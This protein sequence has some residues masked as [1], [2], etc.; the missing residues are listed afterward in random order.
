MTSVPSLSIPLLL[1]LLC[2]LLAD[3]LPSQERTEATTSKPAELLATLDQSY[4]DLVALQVIGESI[5]RLGASARPALDEALAEAA[6]GSNR[7]YHLRL[8]AVGARQDAALLAQLGSMVADEDSKIAALAA[9]LLGRSGAA[10]LA[11]AKELQPHTERE[12]RDG[13][14]LAISMAAA[15]AGCATMLPWLQQRLGSATNRDQRWLPQAHAMLAVGTPAATVQEWLES[16]A[17]RASAIL[18]ARTCADAELEKALLQLYPQIEDEN[19][20][21]WLLHSLG[22]IGGNDTRRALMAD[23]RRNPPREP[24]TQVD[25]RRLALLRLG[26]LEQRKWVLRQLQDNGLGVAGGISVQFVGPAMGQ[27]AEQI[28]K[29]GLIGAAQELAALT[30]DEQVQIWSRSHAARGLCWLRDQRGLLAS[31]SLMQQE[32]T[33]NLD[34]PEC[35]TRCQETLHEFVGNPDR[36]EYVV[37]QVKGFQ[38]DP[39]TAAVG[40]AWQAWLNANAKA[41]VWRTPRYVDSLSL[42]P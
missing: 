19:H 2:M 31:A 35:F 11:I 38:T 34:N 9:R 36:P 26:D 41:I 29:W 30:T 22:A 24:S 39:R 37:F 3:S 13:V 32:I 23:L 4:T 40:A 8:L 15:D 10:P 6:Q 5:A 42:W 7:R 25:A 16:P 1:S 18:L 33:D 21:E 20:R 17:L 12:Q 27:M 14:L 28:G